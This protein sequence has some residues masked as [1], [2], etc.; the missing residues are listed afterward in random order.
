MSDTRKGE[1][2]VDM[3]GKAGL[4]RDDLQQNR[5]ARERASSEAAK[6]DA[7]ASFKIFKE[8]LKR[9]KKQ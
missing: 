6:R 1:K 7:D 2:L 9:L 8:E 4:V 3:R 5:D